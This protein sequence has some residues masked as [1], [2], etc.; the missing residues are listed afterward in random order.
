MKTKKQV[1]DFYDSYAASLKKMNHN[2]R[3]LFLNK[4]MREYG[5][6]RRSTV[7]EIGCGI[8]MVTRFIAK[9]AT[10]GKIVAMDISPGSIEAAKKNLK[11]H[12]NIEF[13][14]GNATEFQY[15]R[16][17]F[18]FI[19][20]F[21]V[22]EHIPVEKHA[23]IFSSL[24]GY[25]N[26]RTLLMINI[27]NPAYIELLEKKSPEALQVIDQPLYADRLL[28]DA[29]KSDLQLFLFETHGIWIQDEYQFIIFKKKSP[30]AVS[31]IR[32]KKVLNL[33]RLF[34]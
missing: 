34:E 3:H 10:D 18:D 23:H 13:F 16:M 8:G 6:G 31:R 21:D 7:L 29:S 17:A 32:S 28:Q 25:M 30:F 2:E 22:L 14:T 26:E 19:I 33:K 9:R 12:D 5:L 20:L 24:S 11:D 15:K 1:I 27:P 4:K